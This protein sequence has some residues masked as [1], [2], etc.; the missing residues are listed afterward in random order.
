MTEDLITGII[1]DNASIR[2]QFLDTSSISSSGTTVAL[3]I[4]M[5]GEKEDLEIEDRWMTVGTRTTGSSFVWNHPT[6]GILGSHSPQGYLGDQRGSITIVRIIQPNNIY[7]ELFYDTQ[8]MGTVTNGTWDVTNHRAV[9]EG[10]EATT[11]TV[12][13]FIQNTSQASAYQFGSKILTKVSGVSLVNIVREA[14]C[15]GAK[16]KL[17]TTAGTLLQTT[18]F[19]GATATFSPVYALSDSTNYYIVIDSNGTAYTRRYL[20]PVSTYPI[21]TDSNINIVCSCANETGPII[22]ITNSSNNIKSITT[23]TTTPSSGTI[24]SSQIYMNNATVNTAILVASYNG[25]VDWYMST[26]GGTAWQPCYS[27]TQITFSTSGT[28]LRWKASGNVATITSLNIAF[29]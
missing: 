11:S 2:Q 29:T 19:S 21:T 24:Q 16:C 28:D 23:S 5:V 3:P 20:F 25:T 27:G 14:S 1:S 15:T 8:F 12:N 22:D 10:G 17:Y 9:L 7:D 18:D 6:Y 26:N 4:F 13:E